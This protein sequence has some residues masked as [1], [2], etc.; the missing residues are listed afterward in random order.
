[1][2]REEIIGT[3][4]VL[5]IAGSETSATLLSGAIYY[6]LKNVEWLKALRDELDAAFG[7]ESEISFK[8]VNQLKILDAVIMETFRLYPPTPGI[9]PRS[10]QENDAT[11]CGAYLPAGTAVGVTQFAANRSSRN[12]KDPERFAPQRFLD[13]D[14]Y[15]YDK[16][17]VLQP[18][19]V[20]P[21]NCIGQVLC[22]SIIDT[23]ML[24]VTESCS[25]RDPYH[26]CSGRLELRHAAPRGVIALG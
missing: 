9:F 24:T 12:F 23:F 13:N 21:R 14:E 15:K 16:R 1:M 7:Q 18:F 17:S 25:R 26:P 19:S 3:M 22:P 11:I 8:S 4:G 20:G 5:I 2:S 6:L 10:P